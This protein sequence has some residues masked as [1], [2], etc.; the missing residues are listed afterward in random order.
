MVALKKTNIICKFYLQ[1]PSTQ[2]EEDVEAEVRKF[3]LRDPI[4][5][6]EDPIV[7]WFTKGNLLYPRLFL[8]ATKYLIAQGTSVP[9]ERLFSSAGQVIT[10]RRNRLT[11]ENAE[12]LI[13]LHHNLA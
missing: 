4:Q 6:S 3:F 10:E 7:W 1:N 11:E 9:S 2:L 5:R 13:I 8:L 12:K